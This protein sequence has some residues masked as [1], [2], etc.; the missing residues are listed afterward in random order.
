MP[1]PP[2]RF[3]NP[4]NFETDALPP[5]LENWD[6]ASYFA[7]A[8]PIFSAVLG[9]NVAHEMGHRVAVGGGAGDGGAVAARRCGACASAPRLPAPHALTCPSRAHARAQAFVR[10]VRLGPTIFVPNF[11]IGSFGG[12]TPF[13][14]ML[15][16]RRARPAQAGTGA[17]HMCALVS[18]PWHAKPRAIAARRSHPRPRPVRVRRTA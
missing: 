12:I 3:A 6:P 16:V 13:T 14:S 18:A 11:Q 9:T 2:P 8:L 10:S 7:N 5:G 15:K 1:P 4:A 17:S